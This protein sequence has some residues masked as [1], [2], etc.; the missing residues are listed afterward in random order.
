MK[1]LL[2]VLALWFL[3]ACSHP[4]EI[5]GEGD[6]ESSTGSNDCEL[7]D[8]PC[9]NIVAGDYNVSYTA[10][11]RSGWEFVGWEG[12]GDQFPNCT[13]NVPASIVNQFSGQVLPPLRAVFTPI[14]GTIVADGKVWLQLDVFGTLAFRWAEVNAL[15]PGGPCSSG[16]LGG[17]DMTGWVWASGDDIKS[18]FN[19]YLDGSPFGASTQVVFAPQIQRM[20]DDGWRLTPGSPPNITGF[21]R[22][23]LSDGTFGSLAQVTDIG[24]TTS[25]QWVVNLPLAKFSLGSAGWFYRSI[26]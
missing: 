15:C 22:D 7:E 4:L 3:G 8:E 6:I 1:L 12:C 11:P 9:S 5:V 14:D 20:L 21:T 16:T 23:E 17:I 18:L 2:V 26:D 25:D 19:T 13:F 10:V 24:N